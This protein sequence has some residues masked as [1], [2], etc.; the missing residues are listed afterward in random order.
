MYMNEK[1]TCKL[2]QDLL[3]NYV[4]KLT[5]KETNQFIENH[6]SECK[7]CSLALENML[8]EINLDANEKN[9]KKV[10]YLQKF[11]NKM[12]ILKIIIFVIL[13]MIILVFLGIIGKRFLVLKEISD[14]SQSS[15]ISTNFHVLQYY[16][17]EGNILKMEQFIMENKNKFSYTMETVDGTITQTT[18]GQ[19]VDSNER[20]SYT[21]NSYME[22]GD[23]KYVVLNDTLSRELPI[24]N[25]LYS[26]NLLDLFK[27][28]IKTT[29]KTTTFRNREC[30]Y[31]TNIPA[32][33]GGIYDRVYI[34]KGTGLMIGSS[35]V[36]TT[37]NTATPIETVYEYCTVTEEDFIEPNISEY[38]IVDDFSNLP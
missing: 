16:Y 17:I 12:K 21:G 27:Y 35:Q 18:Y 38:Q 31:L 10:A 28:S 29:V 9:I 4:E 33:L 36:D 11:K 25:V 30:Y 2:V 1:I 8:K 3:P 34:D 19:I 22:K 37:Q 26:S 24:E 20:N 13:L 6:L 14:K 32:Y 23:K 7:E 15:D 5:D